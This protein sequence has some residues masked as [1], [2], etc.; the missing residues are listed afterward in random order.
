MTPEDQSTTSLQ[1]IAV[2]LVED[3]FLNG[4][5]LQQTL[6]KF[7]CSVVG[8]VASVIQGLELIANETFDIAILD[9]NIIGGTVEPIARKLHQQNRKFIFVTGYGSPQNLPAT[10]KQF[11]RLAKPVAEHDLKDALN[12]IVN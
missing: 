6:Q 3:N 7:G 1:G 10:L 8:P 2:L 5:A 9:I 4:I 12:A 11:T